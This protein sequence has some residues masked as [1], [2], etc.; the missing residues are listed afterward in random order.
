MAILDSAATGDLDQDFL[1]SEDG[2]FLAWAHG[3]Y[4]RELDIQADSRTKR[5][6]DVAFYDGDQ[7]TE[8]ELAEKI[9][10]TR[11]TISK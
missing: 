9:Y 6:N 5:A 11:Q 4:Q 2:Q 8:E 7:H 3:L 10:V 1:D